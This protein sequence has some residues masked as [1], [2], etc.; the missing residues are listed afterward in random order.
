MKTVEWSE[1]RNAISKRVNIPE[2]I[3]DYVANI[4]ILEL[5][6]MGKSADTISTHLGMDIEDVAET[7]KETF[8]TKIW[9]K[10]L[11]FNPLKLYSKFKGNAWEY[12]EYII[13]KFPDI[14]T[15]IIFISYDIVQK[16]LYIKEKVD[17][18]YEDSSA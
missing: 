6:A 7:L 15:D 10:N 1:I 11:E 3:L 5:C 14:S 12:L 17:K 18:C 16:Y 9:D 13:Y 2:V 4:E 8:N